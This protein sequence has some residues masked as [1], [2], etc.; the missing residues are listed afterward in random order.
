M[1]HGIAVVG[2]LGVDAFPGLDFGINTFGF[3]LLSSLMMSCLAAEG[4]L[5][6]GVVAGQN[7][8]MRA[9]IRSDCLAIDPH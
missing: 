9:K 6:I 8:D 4:T 2:L 3:V 1:Q 7:S 5:Q